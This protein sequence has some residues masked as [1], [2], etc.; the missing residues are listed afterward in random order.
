MHINFEFKARHQN[1]A[2]AEKLLLEQ[3]PQF[4][5]E[6]HQVDT[7]FM[8]PKGRLKLREGTI[9]QSL[10]FY[11][12]SNTAGA[13]QSNVIL[14]EHEAD[15]SL[16][17]VLSHALGVKIVVDKIRRIYFID[18]VKFHIDKVEGLGSFIEVEAIDKNGDI[19][20]DKLQDQ[21]RHYQELF[22]IKEV[23]F[24]AESY[25]D[26]LWQKNPQPQLDSF[27]KKL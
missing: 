3:H 5:G 17:Q 6:D 23:D 20:L 27:S 21:C 22:G 15:P 10:I 13:K 24:I 25:S 19:G 12:R 2:L 8:V 11:E 14:Y 18:N 16:K 7:Y 4:I 1:T 9:E 26:L